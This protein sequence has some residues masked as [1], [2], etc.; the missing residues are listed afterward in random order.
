MPD[1]ANDIRPRSRSFTWQ[2]PAAVAREAQLLPGIEFL[3][4]VK[5]GEIRAPIQDTLDF[6]LDDFGEGWSTWTLVPDEYQYNPAG[7][8]HGGVVS[9]LLDTAMGVALWTTLP[10]GAFGTT[11]ELKVNFVRP[12]TRETGPVR[13]EARVIHSGRTIGTAEGKVVDRAGKL[14]AHG[15]TT[16][17]ASF[18]KTG[19]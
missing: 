6:R 5:T 3:R 18:P 16:C 10:T 13:C 7:T 15:T 14:I 2:D 17:M 11:V 9:T 19:R 12:I 8:V 4:K 1:A